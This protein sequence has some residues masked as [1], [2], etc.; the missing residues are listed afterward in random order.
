[1]FT[2]TMPTSC[3]RET[4]FHAHFSETPFRNSWRLTGTQVSDGSAARIP[5]P[6][7]NLENVSLGYVPQSFFSSKT[8]CAG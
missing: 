1:M 2:N 7:Y 8:R 4:F 5:T 6:L 3:G